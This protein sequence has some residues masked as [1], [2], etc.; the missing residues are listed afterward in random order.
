MPTDPQG[1]IYANLRDWAIRCELPIDEALLDGP[2]GPLPPLADYNENL[3]EPLS[4]EVRFQFE[5]G[6]GD[7]L[8]RN[9][10]VL[11]SSSVIAVNAFHYWRQRNELAALAR[12]L[13]LPSSPTEL[14]F[15]D[16]FRKPPDIP[17]HRPNVDLVLR[18][19]DTASLRFVGIESKFVEPYRDDPGWLKPAYSA[20]QVWRRFG[21][22]S[23]HKLAAQLTKPIDPSEKRTRPFKHLNA[24]QLLRHLVAMCEDCGGKEFQL[25]YF[26][27]ETPHAESEL[28]RRE[29]EQFASI[30]ADD[31]IPF[32]SRTY[33]EFI[34]SI[35]K[36]NVASP[37]YV[38][39]LQDRYLWQ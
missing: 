34:R 9:M 36:E 6:E 39:Y 23:S 3:F 25:G 12:V 30:M 16:K 31:G 15:E 35:A 38:A 21:L 37:E 5:A 8:D 24:V 14:R 13:D 29:I 2:P 33:Q 22:S 1:F 10:G 19:P 32:F 26:W 7:E 27:F 17:G 4:D 18:Y 28:H 11:H 20:S